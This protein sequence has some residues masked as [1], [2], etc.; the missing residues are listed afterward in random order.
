MSA[1]LDPLRVEQ[2]GWV[3]GR[4][5]WRTLTPL[6]FRSERLGGIVEIPAEFDFDEASAPRLPLIWLVAGGKGKAA[7]EIHDY[8]YQRGGLVIN[9]VFR[10]LSRSAIDAVFVEAMAADPMSGTDAVD[11]WLM[12]AGVRVAGWYRWNQA[13]ARVRDLNPEWTDSQWP[14]VQAA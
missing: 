3:K 13:A 5:E 11:R 14:E 4:P 7:S 12:W 1:F 10:K 6:R 8:G 2:I 9:G